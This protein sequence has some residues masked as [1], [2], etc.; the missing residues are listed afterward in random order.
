MV[1]ALQVGSVPNNSNLKQK[2][3]AEDPAHSACCPPAKGQFLW[4]WVTSAS[5]IFPMPPT[6]THKSGSF[7]GHNSLD[8]QIK[9]QSETQNTADNHFVSVT[10]V[11]GTEETCLFEL[12]LPHR[13]FTCRMIVQVPAVTSLWVPLHAVTV[14]EQQVLSLS[15]VMMD[16]HW[17]L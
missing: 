3:C 16:F 11:F 15:L 10:V 4:V 12:F 9:L 13:F 5:Q 2:G 1:W 17:L 6:S 14:P 8:V 7:W